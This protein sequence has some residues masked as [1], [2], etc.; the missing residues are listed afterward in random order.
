MSRK[1]KVYY[2]DVW[3]C[4]S[5]LTVRRFHSL[6]SVTPVQLLYNDSYYTNVEFVEDEDKCKSFGCISFYR[7]TDKFGKCSLWYLQSDI[8]F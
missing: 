8:L 3:F 1:K 7:V 5:N 4:D 6:N 2:F